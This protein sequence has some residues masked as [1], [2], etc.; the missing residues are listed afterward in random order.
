M[1]GSTTA[2]AAPQ[3][4]VN[5]L[6]AAPQEAVWIAK[7]LDEPS[8]APTAR[9]VALDVRIANEGHAPGAAVSTEIVRPASELTDYVLSPGGAFALVGFAAGM[10]LLGLRMVH[11]ARRC[12]AYEA[13]S[14]V[15]P[16]TAV[17]AA[18]C[19]E[20]DAHRRGDVDA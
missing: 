1:H 4:Q 9:E 7:V 10:L 8:P 16:A 17:R 18:R 15:P 3:S 6:A 11:S 14:C 12:G 2:Q 20:H 5:R 13:A 19:G